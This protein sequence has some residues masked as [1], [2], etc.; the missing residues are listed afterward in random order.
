M[1]I[2]YVRSYLSISVSIFLQS[3]HFCSIVIAFH[4]LSVNLKAV[5]FK[6]KKLQS[7]C[8]FTHTETQ[9]QSK[10]KP[11]QKNTN[12]H[13]HTKKSTNIPLATF[14]SGKWKETDPLP[15]HQMLWYTKEAVWASIFH[16]RQR[17]HDDSCQ[18]WSVIN[19]RISNKC[20]C[21]EKNIFISPFHKKLFTHSHQYF[22]SFLKEI[23]YSTSLTV[24]TSYIARVEILRLH[25]RNL[26]LTLYKQ[27]GCL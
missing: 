10:R 7:T 25:I 1:L 16:S 23:N 27:L 22:Y 9:T 17:Y 12:K 21:D 3:I 20:S 11:K 18:K 5:I 24:Q 15:E 6:P 4:F 26:D 19:F 13:T 14:W 8:P 2:L